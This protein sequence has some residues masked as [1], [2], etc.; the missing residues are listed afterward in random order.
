MGCKPDVVQKAKFEYSP[1]SQVF[2]KGLD[3]SEKQVGLL[4][5]LKHIEDKTDR[6]LKENK[7]NQLGA[8]SIGYTVKEEL[9]QEA[10][11]MLEN[12]NNQEKLINYKKLSFRRGSNKDYHF[13]NFSSLREL[14]RT[15][16]Y[17]DII[18]PGAERERNN[19]DD[20][21]KI[22]KA[23]RPRNDSKYYKLKRDLLINAQKFYDGRKMIIETVKNKIFPLSNL[24]YYP[25]YVSEDDISSKSSLDSS[26]SSSPKG[27]I[28]A[29]PSCG[30]DSSR[31]SSPINIETIKL[32]NESENIDPEMIRHYFGLDSLKKLH[33]SLN[34]DL[35]NKDI[36]VALIDQYLLGLKID[37]NKSR[38]R[39]Q[40]KQL[41]SLAN[42][43]EKIV[44]DA[45]N[46]QQGRRLK[47]LTS[48][49]MITRL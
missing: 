32:I 42:I 47:I 40:N 34:K 17:G 33:E 25:E 11:N 23:Y 21:I 39:K 48:K 35:S 27:A 9:S 26:R 30:L 45:T 3:T 31:I 46:N 7:G 37:I 36:N 16:Y 6:Q 12:L 13:T 20:I 19:F 28:A 24:G 10:K 15:I 22:L 44:N 49:Q 5:R 4:K 38:E 18:I 43:V 2:N 41:E 14:F 29:S 8:K 1:L